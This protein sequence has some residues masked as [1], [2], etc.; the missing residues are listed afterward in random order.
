[1]TILGAFGSCN[2]GLGGSA[3]MASERM[4]RC[5]TREFAQKRET[6]RATML[7][8]SSV[9]L[10]TPL[11]RANSAQGESFAYIRSQG[12][13]AEQPLSREPDSQADD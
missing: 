13:S 5:Y 1:M 7:G 9:S 8:S 2:G 4:R 11:G 12:S 10:S 6:R 3:A